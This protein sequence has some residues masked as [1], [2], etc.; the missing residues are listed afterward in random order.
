MTQV[1]TKPA[2]QPNGTVRRAS[3]REAARRWQSHALV[4]APSSAAADFAR[5]IA[6]GPIT[7]NRQAAQDQSECPLAKV[8]VDSL[9]CWCA[10]HWRMNSSRSTRRRQS[11]PEF[12][13]VVHRPCSGVCDELERPACF[14]GRHVSIPRDHVGLV[15]LS[16]TGRSVLLDRQGCHRRAL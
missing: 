7:R 3:S 16:P 1:I 8:S 14:A 10:R 9:A 15:M 12:S 2:T 4:N 6:R 13:T 11:G 5:L